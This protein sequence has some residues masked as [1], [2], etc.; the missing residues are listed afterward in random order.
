MRLVDGYF[1][2]IL[3]TFFSNSYLNVPI[4][5]IDFSPA[6]GNQADADCCIKSAYLTTGSTWVVK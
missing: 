2:V 4:S 1:P 3:L 6:F 5:H